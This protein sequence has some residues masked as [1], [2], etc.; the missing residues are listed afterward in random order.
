MKTIKNLMLAAIC[1]IATNAM[2]S[3]LNS[4]DDS[5][6]PTLTEEEQTA[7]LTRLCGTYTG[8]MTYTCTIPAED[9]KQLKTFRNTI[10]DMVWRVNSDKTITVTNFPDS[11]YN[12]AIRGNA[13][14]EKIM[15]NAP[16][17][18]LKCEFAPYKYKNDKGTI[19]YA[20]QL[21]PKTESTESSQY[22]YTKNEFMVD[23]AKYTM[24]FG[25]ALYYGGASSM[26]YQS[27]TDYTM[28]FQLVLADIKCT[29]VQQ[30]QTVPDLIYFKGSKG[31]GY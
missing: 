26:G 3:C 27:K 15:E 5:I 7:Y 2:T 10:K 29:P 14:L 28:E 25:Y 23:D 11:I 19:D 13:N 1:L 16:E 8:E 18:D 20:F 24:Q 4:D 22:A 21:L 31:F 9:G 17:K 12:N 6:D 30:F